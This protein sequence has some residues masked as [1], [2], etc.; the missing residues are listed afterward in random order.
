MFE[1]DEL[2][3]EQCVERFNNDDQ[4]Y[5]LAEECMELGQAALKMKRLDEQYS[6]CDPLDNLKEE[7]THVLIS[8]AVVSKLYNISLADIEKKIEIK[9]QKYGFKN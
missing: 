6:F 4:L 1:I 9:R 5:R 3:V 2:F 8:C 7:M